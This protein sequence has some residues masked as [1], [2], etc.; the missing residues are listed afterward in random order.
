M[1]SGCTLFSKRTAFS[2]ALSPVCA[3]RPSGL[4]S[5]LLRDGAAAVYTAVHVGYYLSI[6]HYLICRVTAAVAPT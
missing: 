6:L 3:Q 4:P 1:L 5:A 2:T